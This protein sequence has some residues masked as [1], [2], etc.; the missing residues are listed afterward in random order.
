[1]NASWTRVLKSAYRREPITSFAV[2]IGAV[3]VAIGSLG[4]SG[5]LL[6]FGLG[7]LG[8]AIA[9]RWW[10]SHKHTVNHSSSA[11]EYYLPS[12]SSRT[13]LP[14]LTQRKNHP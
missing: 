4:A 14:M 12:S 5:P 6:I 1:M 8:T 11:P 3:D 10:Q 9:L 13:Q 7:T 2:T